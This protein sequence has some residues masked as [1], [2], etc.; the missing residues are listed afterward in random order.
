MTSLPQLFQC[1]L[2]D[3]ALLGP[4]LVIIALVLVP[5]TIFMCIV[6]PLI[7]LLS[8]FTLVTL[9]L[10]FAL[11]QPISQIEGGCCRAMAMI[12]FLLALPALNVMSALAFLLATLLYPCLR[13]TNHHGIYDGIDKKVAGMVSC[14]LG[15]VNSLFSCLDS[16]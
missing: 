11:C 13:R 16:C 5:L 8:F 3:I 4:R 15:I 6:P 9:F 14:Y 12:L 1:S 7:L 2:K 10:P